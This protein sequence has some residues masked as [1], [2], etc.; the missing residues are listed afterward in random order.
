MLSSRKICASRGSPMDVTLKT[1]EEV[2]RF[3]RETGNVLLGSAP[4][5]RNAQIVFTE[6]TREG[7]CILCCGEDVTLTGGK[8]VFAGPGS[9][10]YLASGNTSLR[11]DATVHAGCTFALGSSTYTN[12]P[13]HLIVSERRSVLIGDRGLFSFDVWIRTAD[14]H[15]VY[16]VEDSSRINPSRDVVIGDHVWLG[17]SA[18]LLKGTVIGSGSIIGGAAV[19]AGKTIPSNTSWAGSPARQIARGVFFGGACVHGWTAE[20]TAASQTFASDKWIYDNAPQCD[21]SGLVQLANRLAGVTSAEERIAF[22]QSTYLEKG[23]NRFAI[24]EA[25]PSSSSENRGLPLRPLEFLRLRFRR[26]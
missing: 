9:V 6:K 20:Q 5:M 23:K 2:E 12:G 18:M 7:A 19:V 17:Q 10:V 13:L 26:R 24:A 14:P 15:L 25:P 8:L 21:Q 22:V 3:F 4:K 1:T 16:R 11:L